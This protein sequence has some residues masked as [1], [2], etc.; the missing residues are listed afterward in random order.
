M[1]KVSA[2]DWGRGP[3]PR[4]GDLMD[5]EPELIFK[6]PV[7]LWVLEPQ[8]ARMCACLNGEP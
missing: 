8:K 6:G 4:H 1:T 2:S 5:L 7:N 3:G